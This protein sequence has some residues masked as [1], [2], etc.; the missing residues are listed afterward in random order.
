[1]GGLRYVGWTVGILSIFSSCTNSSTPLFITMVWFC[2][3][4]CVCVCVCECGGKRN[5]REREGGKSVNVLLWLPPDHKQRN[6]I[7]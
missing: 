5:K 2:V 1:M 6:S 7:P 4:M 3:H